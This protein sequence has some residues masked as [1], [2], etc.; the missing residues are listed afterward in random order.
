MQGLSESQLKD[1]LQQFSQ[2]Y[3]QE[4][5]PLIPPSPAPPIKILTLEEAAKTK[6]FYCASAIVVIVLEAIG[7]AGI[8]QGSDYN[9]TPSTIWGSVFIAAGSLCFI[10][11][12]AIGIY[13]CVKSRT[14]KRDIVLP[15]IARESSD[16]NINHLDTPAEP[17]DDLFV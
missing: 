15:P 16:E 6:G 1:L 17:G 9:Y 8:K 5:Q 7:I 12:A 11:I 10:S 13:S 4:R 2:Q 3:P 14:P